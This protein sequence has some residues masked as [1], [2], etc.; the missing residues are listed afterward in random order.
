MQQHEKLQNDS[1]CASRK[2]KPFH[3]LLVQWERPSRRTSSGQKQ[4]NKRLDNDR[5]TWTLQQL[6]NDKP[7][8]P[9]WRIIVVD[10]RIQIKFS[11]I[12][13]TKDAIVEPTCEQLHKWQQSNIGITHLRLDNAGQNKLLQTRCASKDWKMNCEFEFTARDTP[14]QNSLAEVGFATLANHRQAMM[15]HANLP[16]M[17]RYR[18]AHETFQCATHLGGLTVVEVYGVTKTR[19]EHF[20]RQ[21]PMFAKH[22]RTWG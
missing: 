2:H 5:L 15:H 9:N 19:Y 11:K 8:K 22:L 6:E 3:A 20:I 21:N 16:M 17:D 14:Q 7:S 1:V 13:K 4:Q 12:F 10:Q 18:L